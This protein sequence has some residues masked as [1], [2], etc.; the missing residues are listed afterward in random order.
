MVAT[1]LLIGTRKGLFIARRHPDRGWQL[2]PPKLPGVSVPYAMRDPRTG[3]LWVSVR[4]G[5]WGPKLYRSEDGGETLTEVR[6]PRYPEDA[7]LGGGGPA[8][9]QQIW[10][11]APGHPD[12]PEVLFLGT[13]PGG[14]FRSEDGGQTFAL[15]RG[16]WDAEGR[17]KWFGGGYDHPGVHSLLVDPRDPAR[18]VAGIS[19]GGI[20]ET[21]DGGASWTPWGAGLNATFL[22]TPDAAVGQDPHLLAAC[23]VA[24]EVIWQQHHSGVYRSVDGGHSWTEVTQKDGPVGFGFPIA[25]HPA[26]PDT[27]WVVPAISDD[28]RMAVD[29]KLRVC[30]TDDGGQTWRDQREGLP[31]EGAWDVVYRHALDVDVRGERLAFG[32]TTGNLFVS[33]DGGERWTSVSHHLPQVYSV[34]FEAPQ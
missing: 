31:T 33:E 19:C 34:R 17:E 8:T 3:T 24:P 20:Y 12:E 16:L 15:V 2:G 30:R 9:L 13:I 5:H 11:V 21:L 26:R 22:P 28:K 10:T 32:S 14:L 27:A 23:P 6:P 18:M 7:L 25:V 4:H 29:G 1:R